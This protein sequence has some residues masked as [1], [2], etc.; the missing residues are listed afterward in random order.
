MTVSLNLVMIVKNESAV[1]A[2]CLESAKPYVDKMIVVD[3]GSTDDTA[4]IATRLGAELHHFTWIDDFSA[5]RNAA[6]AYSDAEWNFILDADEW[7][8][9]GGDRLRRIIS[10]AAPFIGLATVASDV[11]V[12]GRVEQAVNLL[13]RLLPKGARYTGTIHEQ[14]VGFP[15]Q[16][17]DVR[18]GHGGYRKSVMEKKKGRN[19]S[20]LIKAVESD[21]TNDYLIYQ[22]GKSYEVYEDYAHA[23]IY[24]ER[25]LPLTPKNKPYRRDLVIGAIHAFKKTGKHQKAIDLSEAEYDNWQHAADFFFIVGDLYLDVA[26][27]Q[28][29]K[30]VSEILPL[31]EH[32][33]KKAIELGEMAESAGG[34]KG[35]GS[36]MPAE[37]LSKLY[38]E[39]GLHDLAKEYAEK[40]R[41]MRQS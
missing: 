10:G 13:P 26:S 11:D 29:Q 28:P 3:T 9:Q 37:N 16:N 31:V 24:F 8:E 25:A 36:F 20:L 1:L 14:P 30:A 34:V 38:G 17:I 40:A 41:Q 12:D 5:A 27:L 4:T 15:H 32:C 18:I 22:L 39:L 19:Q 6:L 23:A 2:R 21:P 35:H 33:W 7:I